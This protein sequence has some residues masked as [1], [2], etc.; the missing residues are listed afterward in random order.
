M[1]ARAA[2]RA[3]DVPVTDVLTRQYNDDITKYTTTLQHINARIIER[4]TE[5]RQVRDELLGIRQDSDGNVVEVKDMNDAN[6][7][8]VRRGS[9]KIK[10]LQTQLESDNRLR[11]HMQSKLDDAMSA[12]AAGVPQGAASAASAASVNLEVASASPASAQRSPSP[13]PSSTKGCFDCFR[14]NSNKSK[15]ATAGGRKSRIRKLKTKRTYK[16]RRTSRK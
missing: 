1:S 11:V 15:S 6:K 16:K 13:S 14:G 9:E 3:V 12:A 5:Y 7:A 4:E 2:V 10:T 8:K